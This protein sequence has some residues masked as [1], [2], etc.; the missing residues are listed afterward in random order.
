M[1][2][3]VTDMPL[4]PYPLEYS[5]LST[6]ALSSSSS[7]ENAQDFTLRAPSKLKTTTQVVA[8]NRCCWSLSVFFFDHQPEPFWSCWD[9]KEDSVSTEFKTSKLKIRSSKERTSLYFK[10]RFQDWC[11]GSCWC[12]KQR[13]CLQDSSDEIAER[14]EYQGYFLW[15]LQTQNWHSRGCQKI[16]EQGVGAWEVLTHTVPFSEINKA[17]AYM[18]KRE[19]MHCIITMV[20]ETN[21]L[22][23]IMYTLCEC[24]VDISYCFW[25]LKSLIYYHI[26]VIVFILIKKYITFP[27]KRVCIQHS[28]CKR[29]NRS[30]SKGLPLPSFSRFTLILATPP[31][32]QTQLQFSTSKETSLNMLQEC[33]QLSLICNLS[34]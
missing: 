30:D 17:F 4:T 22:L 13:R 33:T 16:H 9:Q 29:T 32:P 6:L 23:P 14:E 1:V 7:D 31:P 10:P 21:I 26:V 3:S 5:L 11:C 19:S 27:F 18:L 28:E 8:L 24:L 2:S 20:L 12:A 25:F 34:G 15:Q